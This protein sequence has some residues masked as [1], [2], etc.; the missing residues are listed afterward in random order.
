M[1]FSDPL[2]DGPVIQR[3]TERAL[4]AGGSL[5]ASLAMIATVRAARRRRRSSSSATPTRCCGSGWTRSRAQA[6]D[7][8]R[9]RRAGAR[10]ADRGGGRVPRAAGRRR[11]STRSSCSA[12]RRPTRGSGRR[13]RSAAAFS[14]ASRGS[15]SPARATRSRPARE[16]LVRAD[17]RAHDAAD[18]ARLRHLAARSTSPRSARYAD[19]AVVGSALVVVDRRGTARRRMLVDRVESVRALAEGSGSRAMPTLDDLRKR[20]RPRRRSARRAC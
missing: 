19:A 20:H 10:P 6:A 17:P 3:A 2:A 14:T 8:R 7:G 18:R 1:P 5:R 11:A 15:A 4:A 16:A 12:R 13:R 9:R